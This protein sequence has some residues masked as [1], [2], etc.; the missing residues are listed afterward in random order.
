MR[1]AGYDIKITKIL[2]FKQKSIFEEHIKFLYSKKKEYSLKKINGVLYKNINELIL[3][4][5]AY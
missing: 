4:I 2:E 3:W 5:Y 1:T